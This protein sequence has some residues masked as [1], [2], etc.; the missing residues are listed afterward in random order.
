MI[1]GILSGGAILW[2]SKTDL[3]WG[4]HLILIV[5]AIVAFTLF[6]I[7]R[8]KRVFVKKAQPPTHEELSRQLREWLYKYKYPV[9]D[10]PAE[11]T[12]FQFV[13]EFPGQDG[14]ITISR[15]KEDP[16]RLVFTTSVT[17][18]GYAQDQINSLP[19]HEAKRLVS[20]MTL[21]F[22]T[23]GLNFR[24][25]GYP[26]ERVEFQD[27]VPLSDG[28]IDEYDLINELM[29]VERGFR[30]FTVMLSKIKEYGYKEENTIE[31]KKKAKYGQGGSA[32][33]V[34]MD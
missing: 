33:G 34:T 18:S 25:I 10:R 24:G 14:G 12:H 17:L 21:A 31:L 3:W 11:N 2:A 1:L 13:A 26:L 20:D 28:T 9:I 16:S 8:G 15:T 7:D 5:V 27:F 23:F 22:L 6:A 32:D 30:L 19:P 4:P 29:F